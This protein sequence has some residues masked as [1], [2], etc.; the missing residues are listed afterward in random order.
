M[1]EFKLNVNNADLL[2]GYSRSVEVDVLLLRRLA[3]TGD[4][5][6]E[7][8]QEISDRL[9]IR[10]MELRRI[11]ESE[12]DLTPDGLVP[13]MDMPD[14]LGL[15]VEDIPSDS[16]HLTD[17]KYLWGGNNDGKIVYQEIEFDRRVPVEGWTAVPKADVV[18]DT[19]NP[20]K[21]DYS[22]VDDV[23]TPM[24]FPV[25][26]HGDGTYTAGCT[27]GTY[28]EINVK[29]D[30]GLADLELVDGVMRSEIY[31]CTEDDIVLLSATLNDMNGN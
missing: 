21:A 5:T 1:I 18:V 17:I 10:S 30:E 3:R 2:Q 26:D 7:L 12:V 31:T 13:Y 20:V 15:Q 9:E 6:T 28:E 16:L 4:L 23:V 8:G 19:H 11:L 29:I 14:L 22:L 25:E 24:Y 27:T